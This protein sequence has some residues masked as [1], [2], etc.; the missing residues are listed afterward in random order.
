MMRQRLP[1]RQMAC[2]LQ[3]LFMPRIGG[4]P[5]KRQLSIFCLAAYE[6]G[7]SPRR[8]VDCG[9][10][11]QSLLRDA[12]VWTP[13]PV[14]DLAATRSARSLF[15]PIAPWHTLG[16][17]SGRLQSGEP[18][19]CLCFATGADERCLV[20]KPRSHAHFLHGAPLRLCQQVNNLRQAAKAG[21]LVSLCQKRAT[22]ACLL[23]WLGLM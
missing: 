10:V 23:R 13:I 2:T 16:V 18:C 20:V 15:H 19:C 22:A 21:L 6:G 8:A 3:A 1:L 7:Q 4:C 12:A 14:G 17:S 9:S 5:P 11:G